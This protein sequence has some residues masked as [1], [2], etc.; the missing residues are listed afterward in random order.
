M[1][2]LT[3]VSKSQMKTILITFFGIKGIFHFEF[4]PQDRTVNQAYYL[5]IL[6]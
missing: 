4:I 5:G 6:K 3:H 2:K 1:K